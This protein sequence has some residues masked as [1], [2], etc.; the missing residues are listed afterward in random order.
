VGC[1]WPL[2]P[3]GIELALVDLVT[4]AIFDPDLGVP[5]GAKMLGIADGALDRIAMYLRQRAI[6]GAPL[7]YEWK[8]GHSRIPAALLRARRKRPHRCRAAEKRDEFAPSHVT[9]Q[10]GSWS[11]SKDSRIMPGLC[12]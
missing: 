3:L 10:P 9:T 12:E 11:S 6:F 4:F 1:F 8:V 7:H 5:R 2:G